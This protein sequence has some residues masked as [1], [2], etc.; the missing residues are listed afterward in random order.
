MLRSRSHIYID[1][2]P[3]HVVDRIKYL[4]CLKRDIHP[5]TRLFLGGRNICVEQQRSGART[6]PPK[7]RAV[8]ECKSRASLPSDIRSKSRQ[9]CSNIQNRSSC[10]VTVRMLTC[11]LT[12]SHR[13]C[14]GLLGLSRH[15]VARSDVWI[16]SRRGQAA[17][18]TMEISGGR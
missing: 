1:R 16:V 13:L 11:A 14:V 10:I 7:P 3:S 6:S 17:R 18:R 8:V 9:M 15:E 4:V 5:F 12:V 2:L